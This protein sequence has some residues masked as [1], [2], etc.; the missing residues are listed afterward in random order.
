[1]SIPCAVLMGATAFLIGAVIVL[2]FKIGGPETC[3]PPYR[4][5]REEENLEKLRDTRLRLESSN[6]ALTEE[7]RDLKQK[8]EI[9]DKILEDRG[10]EDK[11]LKE[12]LERVGVKITY[13]Y[14]GYYGA[15]KYTTVRNTLTPEVEKLRKLLNTYRPEEI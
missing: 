15:T 3:E 4:P 6:R 10:K 12:M 7:N 5:Y 9:R 14:G 8:V 11:E 1:M 13:T 2:A